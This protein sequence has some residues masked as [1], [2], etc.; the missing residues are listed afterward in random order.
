[1]LRAWALSVHPDE[2]NWK[3]ATLLVLSGTQS[4]GKPLPQHCGDRGAGPGGC[5][6]KCYQS[7]ALLGFQASLVL[8]SWV[9]QRW[10]GIP[11][12][13]PPTS[14]AHSSRWPSYQQTGKSPCDV[15]RV[16]QTVASEP[17]SQVPQSEEHCTV[18]DFMWFQT[19]LRV[20]FLF[21][22]RMMLGFW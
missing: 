12:P 2:E 13:K 10:W 4:T 6:V 19:S 17:A 1:M 3:P 20:A 22:W 14:P 11:G 18:W 8:K 21:L 7:G 16:W 15:G 5:C 9:V